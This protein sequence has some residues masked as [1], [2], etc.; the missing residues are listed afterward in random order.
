MNTI[1][2]MALLTTLALMTGCGTLTTLPDRNGEYY[3]S[4]HRDCEAIKFA[5]H[6]SPYALIQLGPI[7]SVPWVVCWGLDL[8]ISL[9][10]DTLLI[11]YDY[12]QGRRK[13]FYMFVVDENGTP[14]PGATIRGFSR[15]S[16]GG[17]TDDQGVFRWA[18]DSRSI[19]WFTLSKA[20]Y[21]ETEQHP[22]QR[23]TVTAELAAARTNVLGVV[24]KRCRNPIAMYA[25]QASVDLPTVSGAYGYDLMVGDL[26]APHGKGSVTD[27]VFHVAKGKSLYGLDLDITFSSPIDG[28]Q[29][30]DSSREH[31][32]DG[33]RQSAYIFPYDA[34]SDGYKPSLSA[35]DTAVD[36][37]RNEREKGENLYHNGNYLFRVR[38]D[39]VTN[40]LY[41]RVYGFFRAGIHGTTIP[42]VEFT[43]FLNSTGT[44][45]LEWD[46][47]R[48]LI[49]KMSRYR[50]HEY[51]PNVK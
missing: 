32:N 27:F 10:T 31:G 26:V 47:T 37:G 34:P 21:Y 3:L 22:R 28:I 16:V 29:R 8:P 15:R 36:I 23:A 30:Y 39:S 4:S 49:T 9:T 1:I 12:L 44:R 14:V 11:P 41:G 35:A 13:G 17:L 45:S 2:K 18:S 19:E 5:A 50:T 24:L 25:K 38:S 33:P 46:G 48:N 20:G 43:Y 6:P 40:G 51:Q 7:L 42:N